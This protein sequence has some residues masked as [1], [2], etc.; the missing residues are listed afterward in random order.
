MLTILSFVAP[1]V[2][3]LLLNY[4]KV[5]NKQIVMALAICYTIALGAFFLFGYN[6]FDDLTVQKGARNNA[7]TTSLAIQLAIFLVFLFRYKQR[8]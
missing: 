2:V 7:L 3:A 1:I 6:G 8:G 4:F 5:P